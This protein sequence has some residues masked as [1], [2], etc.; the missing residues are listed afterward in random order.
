MDLSQVDWKPVVG[1]FKIS[2]AHWCHDRGRESPEV[3]Y[4]QL[5][6]PR[7]TLIDKYHNYSWTS[8]LKALYTP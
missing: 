2:A 3:S 1:V 4:Q 5:R 7:S 8:N 6:W